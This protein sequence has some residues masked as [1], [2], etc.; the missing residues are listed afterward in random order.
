MFASAWCVSATLGP[1]VLFH[2]SMSVVPLMSLLILLLREVLNMALLLVRVL[3][4]LHLIS[5]ITLSGFRVFH[6]I[7]GAGCGVFKEQKLDVEDLLSG[8]G[9]NLSFESDM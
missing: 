9:I 6:I 3:R 2:M 1:I 7:K 5:T 4:T 8:F